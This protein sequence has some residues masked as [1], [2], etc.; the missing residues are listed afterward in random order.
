MKSCY[1]TFEASTQLSIS[2]GV[3]QM[4]GFLL[5]TNNGHH[6]EKLQTPKY[7]TVWK[8][9]V[10]KYEILVNFLH[11]VTRESIVLLSKRNYCFLLEMV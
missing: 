3:L 1:C 9:K 4:T 7:I 11:V 5:I 8:R 2:I 10:V 6:T